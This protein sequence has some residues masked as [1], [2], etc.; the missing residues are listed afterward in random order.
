MTSNDPAELED[1]HQRTDDT[2]VESRTSDTEASAR[3]MPKPFGS[4]LQRLGAAGITIV[5]CA[6]GFVLQGFFAGVGA[7]VLM[8]GIALITIHG[9]TDDYEEATI[10]ILGVVSVLLGLNL[11]GLP[12]FPWLPP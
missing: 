4:R 12:L 10:T 8:S 9:I 1:R 5:G 11:L 6:A 2:G 3:T 7:I